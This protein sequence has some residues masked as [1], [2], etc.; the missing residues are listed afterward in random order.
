MG[1]AGPD[2]KPPCVAVVVVVCSGSC[3]R[4]GNLLVADDGEIEVRRSCDMMLFVC[5]DLRKVQVQVQVRAGLGL[6]N[7]RLQSAH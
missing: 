4:S 5:A 7:F 2:S 6:G 1:D 3:D